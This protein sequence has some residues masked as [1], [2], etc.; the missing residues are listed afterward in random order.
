MDIQVKRLTEPEIRQVYC[1]WIKQDFP[2][3]E[4]KPLWMI[5]RLV[6]KGLYDPFA[7]FDGRGF[8]GYCL[9]IRQPGERPGYLVD[10]LAVAKDRR[11]QGYGTAFQKA[12]ISQEL[13]A[14]SFLLCEVE[15][16]ETEPDEEARRQQLRRLSFYTGASWKDTE[17]RVSTFKAEFQLLEYPLTTVHSPDAVRQMYRDIWRL[18]LPGIICD[19]KIIFH[20]GREREGF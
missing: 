1:K 5:L 2:R 15:N 19:R 4:Q 3:D 11:G 18:S 16:P 12:L 20:A 17:V 9:L 6:K 13:K 10:Y 8:A 14:G 7:C